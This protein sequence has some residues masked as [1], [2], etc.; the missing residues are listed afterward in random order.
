LLL[1]KRKKIDKLE[2]LALRKAELVQEIESVNEVIYG[3]IQ[4]VQLITSE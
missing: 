1:K 3:I 2:D 4:M